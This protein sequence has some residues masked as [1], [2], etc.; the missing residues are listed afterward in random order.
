MDVLNRMTNLR[1]PQFILAI[2]D[3]ATLL[4]EGGT[5]LASSYDSAQFKLVLV[6]KT[7]PDRTEVSQEA[8]M[9]R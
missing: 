9:Q 7:A 8:P 4:P 3:H 2:H 6:S 1:L 5:H